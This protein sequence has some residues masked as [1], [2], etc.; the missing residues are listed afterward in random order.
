MFPSTFEYTT[1]SSVEH[2]I[3]LF[4][5]HGEDSQYIAGGHS[6]LPMMKLRVANPTAL[7]DIS[8]ISDL[9]DIHVSDDRVRIGSGARH[10][11]LL[12]HPELKEATNIFSKVAPQI[13]DTQVRNR[14][15]IGG[16]VANA[17][18]S[19]DWPAT[20]LLLNAEMII[21]GE[22]GERR[23]PAEDFFLGLFETALEEGELLKAIEFN[24]PPQNAT[25]DYIKFRNPASGYA[26]A[27]AA[28]MCVLNGPKIAE[29]RVALTGVAE[30]AF[31]VPLVEKAL[32]GVDALDVLE[33]HA[34]YDVMSGHEA[35]S[36]GYADSEYREE[37][38]ATLVHRAIRKVLRAAMID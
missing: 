6:L 4:K 8:K 35:L 5:E 14:G 17:D 18:P 34:S 11:D 31:R 21:A 29:L 36:D 9:A 15:T 25:A 19:A 13:A 7:I 24:R 28:A 12:R 33:S 32:I 2:A 26:V 38:A 3:S 23:V 1:A 22:T 27:G 37:L 10:V 30:H 16:S 20:T